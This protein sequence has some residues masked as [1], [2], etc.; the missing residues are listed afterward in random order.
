MTRARFLFYAKTSAGSKKI[1]SVLSLAVRSNRW[2][3]DRGDIPFLGQ[4]L[5]F[6]QHDKSVPCLQG[7][8]WRLNRTGTR[9]KAEAFESRGF[10]MEL[11]CWKLNRK[12]PFFV[13]RCLQPE[14]N[15]K[16][17]YLSTLQKCPYHKRL[18]GNGL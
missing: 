1:V 10:G 15:R 14:Y 5:R 2:A 9:M 11:P 6:A 13:R 4:M 8:L 7:M 16:R 18:I 17:H 12:C 3:Q